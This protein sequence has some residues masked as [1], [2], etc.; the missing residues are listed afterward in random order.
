MGVRGEILSCAESQ[1]HTCAPLE[2]AIILVLSGAWPVGPGP[3]LR[4]GGNFTQDTL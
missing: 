1:P 2:F 4:S 3:A